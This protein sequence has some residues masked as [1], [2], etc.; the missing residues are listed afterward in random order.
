MT[1]FNDRKTPIP[2]AAPFDDL[3]DYFLT[4]GADEKAAVALENEI[5][6]FADKLRPVTLFIAQRYRKTVD[7]I[8][9]ENLYEVFENKPEEKDSSVLPTLPKMDRNDS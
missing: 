8:L 6:S 1:T 2:L 9:A 7:I 5:L 3:A 4:G